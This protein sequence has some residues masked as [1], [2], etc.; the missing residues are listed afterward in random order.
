MT[1]EPTDS[2]PSARWADVRG[3]QF[4]ISTLEPAFEGFW[5]RAEAGSWEPETFR[6]MD[7]I[8]TSESRFVDIG[9]WIGPTTLYAASRGAAVAAYECDPVAL[10]VLRRNVRL[11]PGLQDR[12]VIHEHALG[13]AD[14]FMRLWSEELGNSET[15]IFS[16]HER[17]GTVRHCGQ[18]VLVG[19]RDVLDVFRE[20]GHSACDTALIKI[21]VEGSE[22]RIVPRLSDVIAS[23]SAVWYVSFHELNINPSDIPA[24]PMRIAEMIRSLAVFAELHWYDATLTELDKDKTCGSIV[25]GTWPSHSSLVFSSRPLSA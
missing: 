11:N 13:E 10:Q 18:S 6:L 8:L 7:T 15:S 21:D 1:G 9:A 20:S 17:E 14:G 12:I 25:D 22:F 23:S 4:R 3:A 24:R 16:D 2:V 19:V 5:S